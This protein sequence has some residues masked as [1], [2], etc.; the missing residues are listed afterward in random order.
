MRDIKVG[1]TIRILEMVGEPQYTNVV[2]V[3]THIDDA[4]QIHGTWGGCAVCADYGDRFEVVPIS[5]DGAKI[6]LKVAKNF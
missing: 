1:D 3:V 4:N 6:L 2:G 5:E